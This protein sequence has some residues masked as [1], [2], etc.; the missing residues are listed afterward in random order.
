ML[1]NNDFGGV[2]YPEKRVSKKSLDSLF[3]SP[4]QLSYAE[5]VWGDN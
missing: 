1:I 4:V 3:G 2:E 5:P